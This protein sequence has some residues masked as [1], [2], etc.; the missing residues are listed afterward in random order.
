[1]WLAWALTATGLPRLLRT[2]SLGFLAGGI[3]LGLMMHL[4][5]AGFPYG[6]YAALNAALES[7]F[8]AGDVIVHSSKLTV[9]PAIYYDHDRSLEQRFIADP[10]GSTVDTFAQATQDV[11]G[12]RAS[13]SIESATAGAKR[14]WFVIF[15]KSIDEAVAADLPTHPHI[16]W[17]DEHFHR[18]NVETWGE[19]LLYTYTP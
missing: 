18:Q 17:F 6:P 16:T 8:A 5:Y 3:A 7:R 2:L 11:L 12:I 1:L 4:T 14:I 19:I 9:L 15:Q 13:D 10:P